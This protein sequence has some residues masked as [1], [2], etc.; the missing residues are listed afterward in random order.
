MPVIREIMNANWYFMGWYKAYVYVLLLKNTKLIIRKYVG[1]VITFNNKIH[2][3]IYGK[4]LLVVIN[5]NN[6]APK[7]T[8]GGIAIK[9]KIIHTKFQQ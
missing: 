5:I 8:K 6:F 9:L 1:I 7:E 3:I 4:V 2:V